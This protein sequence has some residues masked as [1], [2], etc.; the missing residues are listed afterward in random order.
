M[1]PGFRQEQWEQVMAF[2]SGTNSRCIELVTLTLHQHAE[3]GEDSQTKI[4]VPVT[5]EKSPKTTDQ[6]DKTKPL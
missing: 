3:G 2:R 1:L 6:K 4:P 5:K